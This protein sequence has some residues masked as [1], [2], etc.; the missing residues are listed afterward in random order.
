MPTDKPTTALGMLGLLI[1]RCDA[2]AEWALS[3]SDA[4]IFRECARD[5]RAIEKAVSAD[6]DAAL[7]GRRSDR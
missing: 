7:Y 5:A 2:A 4:G 3:T 1:A 6:R